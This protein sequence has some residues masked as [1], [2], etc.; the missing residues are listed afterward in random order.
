[1]A[2][3]GMVA[4]PADK[5]AGHGAR[6]KRESQMTVLV[7]DPVAQPPLPDC[8][9]GGEDWPEQTVRWWAMWKDDPLAAEFREVDWAELLDCALI[10]AEVWSGNVRM[11][12]EL[13]LRTQMFGTTAESRARLRIQFA[14]A[15]EADDKRERRRSGQVGESTKKRYSKLRAVDS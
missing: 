11:A 6:K 14:A 3:K 8:R 9:P 13:R 12:N 1:M 2:G 7:S 10:H 5:L 15:D 4:K